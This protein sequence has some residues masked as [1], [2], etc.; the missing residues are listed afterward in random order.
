MV[1]STQT[2]DQSDSGVDDSLQWR[3]SGVGQPGEQSVAVVE[4]REN[5][6]GDKIGGY[7][8]TKQPSNLTQSSEME[9][10]VCVVLETCACMFSSPSNWTPRSRTADAG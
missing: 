2:V 7:V 5:R 1:S 8:T 4:P 10:H 9:K 6:C 3:Y